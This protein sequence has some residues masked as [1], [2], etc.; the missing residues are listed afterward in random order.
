MFLVALLLAQAAPFD[1]K[2]DFL[3]LAKQH[4]AGEWPNDFSMQN[5]CLKGQAEGMLR[6]KAASD[7]IGKPLEKAL[8]KC[9]EQWTK[10]RVPDWSMIGYCAK[11]Q[12]DDYLKINASR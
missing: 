1:T 2:A 8:E 12:A 11:N 10:A 4:C 7:T 3:D 9:T 5:Y 6:F